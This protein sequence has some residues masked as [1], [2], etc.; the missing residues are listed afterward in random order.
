MK[1]LINLIREFDTGDIA[2]PIMQ[3]DYVWRPRK[4]EAILDSLYKGW[5]VGS[6][7]LWRPSKKQPQKD[8]HSGKA[9]SG[10]AVMYLLDGQQRL[11]SL[12][13][14]IKDASGDILLPPLGK[15][16]SQALAGEPSLMWSMR[17][18]TRALS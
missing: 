3:R 4:V 5:P 1:K 9:A 12:S 16:Q 15:K 6:F 2:L 18:R 8:H 7:Y 14:A 10:A 11:A 17:M 13:R